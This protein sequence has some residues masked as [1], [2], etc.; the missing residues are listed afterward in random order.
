LVVDI[1][2]NEIGDAQWERSAREG[3]RRDCGS[4]V[5]GGGGKEEVANGDFHMR[6]LADPGQGCMVLVANTLQLSDFRGL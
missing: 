5:V 1:Q 3:S 4:V 2:K 6:L